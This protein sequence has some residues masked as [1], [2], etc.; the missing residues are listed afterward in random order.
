MVSADIKADDVKQQEIKELVA[1]SYNFCFLYMHDSWAQISYSYA[2]W[3]FHNKN[4]RIRLFET[5]G[6]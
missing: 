6:D 2:S 3:L 4:F 1:V 5:D